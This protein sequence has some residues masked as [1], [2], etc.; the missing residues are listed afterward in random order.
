MVASRNTCIQFDENCCVASG[1]RIFT[2]S[3]FSWSASRSSSTPAGGGAALACKVYKSHA[4][5]QQEHIFLH[6][7]LHPTTFITAITARVKLVCSSFSWARFTFESSC[8]SNHRTR[9]ICALSLLARR[10]CSTGSRTASN[11]FC[12]LRIEEKHSFEI[13]NS[14][15][16]ILKW[17]PEISHRTATA[18]D[19][20]WDKASLRELM[21]RNILKPP[22]CLS[23]LLCV[24]NVWLSFQSP[25][26]PSGA[27]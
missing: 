18:T 17:S 24:S 5:E 27:S 4:T 7:N 6:I 20:L 11:I 9:A 16:R 2:S 14:Q 19:C 15:E 10:T 8:S 26:T 13:P 22:Q 23:I 12:K 21:Q 25:S 3:L 1:T